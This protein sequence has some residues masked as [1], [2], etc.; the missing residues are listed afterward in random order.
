MRE[1][2]VLFACN[3]NTVRSP[4]AA[5]L[6]LRQDGDMTVESCG[7]SAGETV[8]PFAWAVMHELGLDLVD[9]RPR[10]F[11][12]VDPGDFDVIIALTAEAG[13][14]ADALGARGSVPVE[15]WPIGDPALQEGSREQRLLA[16]RDVRDD[17]LRRLAARFG[18]A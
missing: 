17:L 9:H 3:W 1:R 16:Y 5:A 6:L 13:P 12:D 14:P 7:L 10:T 4:M 18:G 11:A 15:H 2:R 8:D